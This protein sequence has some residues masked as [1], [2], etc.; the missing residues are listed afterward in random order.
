[1]RA[2]RRW[3]LRCLL[4]AV[5]AYV[6]AGVLART[7]AHRLLFYKMPPAYPIGGEYVMLTAED[8]VRLAALDLPHPDAR[9]TIL[10]FHGNGSELGMDRAIHEG[11][12]R[13]GDSV[14]AVDYRG[15]GRSEGVPSERGLYADARAALAYLREVRHV[16]PAQV[17]VY[18]FSL[19]GGPATQ[20]ASESAVAGLVLQ[21]TFQSAFAVE[22]PLA[23]A[24]GAPFDCF[25]NRAKLGRVA[26]PV[27][28]FHGTD[29][30]VIGFSHGLALAEAAR[31]PVRFERVSGAGHNDLPATMGDR[32]WTVLADWTAALPA[33]NN[34]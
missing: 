14:L 13:R 30:G 7:A 17:I 16:S 25:R 15:Y 33:Q 26:C 11:F 9:Y 6:A 8:G 27:L 4:V 12:L 29:D 3:F 22:S 34:P 31:G 24:L 5:L 19:G 1:M 32:Y 10:Y 28:I 2:R 21:S 23:A 20:L 18:G